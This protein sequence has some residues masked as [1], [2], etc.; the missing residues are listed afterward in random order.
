M[1]LLAIIGADLKPEHVS[2]LSS[3]GFIKFLTPMVAFHGISKQYLQRM[4]DQQQQQQA[5]VQAQAQ[6]QA[7][8]TSSSSALSLS[9]G[10][11]FQGK[12]K[13]KSSFPLSALHTHMNALNIQQQLDHVTANAKARYM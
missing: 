5:Q 11:S 13:S 6:A 3:I 10:V 8:S 12:G 9:E 4:I 1:Q 2:F 7:T